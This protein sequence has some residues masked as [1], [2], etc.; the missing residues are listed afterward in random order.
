M[1]ALITAAAAV[2]ALLVIAIVVIL[3]GNG[4]G[5]GQVNPTP[6]V[7]GGSSGV[8]G[9]ASTAF[10][11]FF[12]ST[13][14]RDYVRPYYDDITSCKKTTTASIAS[15]QCVFKTGVEAGL[16]QIPD[17]ITVKDLRDQL[18]PLLTNAKKTTWRDGELW[19]AEVSSSPALYWDVEDKRIA[20]VAVLPSGDADALRSW[21]SARF[22]A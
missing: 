1:P 12:T 10:D 8:P 14:L 9:T 17:T 19:T 22:G 5:G 4:G 15:V 18:D 3:S 16:F 11:S 2:A 7:A 13:E 6:T 21:W 20:A